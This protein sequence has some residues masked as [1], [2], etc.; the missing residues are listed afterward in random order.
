MA[1][2]VESA[3]LFYGRLDGRKNWPTR[4]GWQHMK[5]QGASSKTAGFDFGWP[6]QVIPAG[7]ILIHLDAV[8]MWS[9][10]S[11]IT[12]LWKLS[13]L[14]SATLQGLNKVEERQKKWRRTDC[15]IWRRSRATKLGSWWWSQPVCRLRYRR[16]PLLRIACRLAEESLRLTSVVPLKGWF[17]TNGFEIHIIAHGITSRVRSLR[18]CTDKLAQARS[19]KWIFRLR[20][21]HALFWFSGD[22]CNN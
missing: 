6:I 9:E 3:T 10:W 8:L 12:S 4:F 15:R 7:P 22:N 14:S 17:G 19:W 11:W 2:W 13:G 5:E 21:V 18:I 16:V 20:F 1:A